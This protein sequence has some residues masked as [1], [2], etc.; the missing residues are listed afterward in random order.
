MD[1]PPT[2]RHPKSRT[3]ANLFGC[4]TAK[5]TAGMNRR[6]QRHVARVVCPRRNKFFVPLRE[7]HFESPPSLASVS[8][9]LTGADGAFS[10]ARFWAREAA[11]YCPAAFSWKSNRPSLPV[12]VWMHL[13]SPVLRGVLHNAEHLAV[14]K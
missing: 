10:K 6:S 12:I 3:F 2:N 8:L 4:D 1:A 7:R 11:G 14:E 13:R 5:K 9:A